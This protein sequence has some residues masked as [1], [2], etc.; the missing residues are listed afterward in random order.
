M[1]SRAL[2]TPHSH[3]VAGVIYILNIVHVCQQLLRRPGV[4]RSLCGR[5]RTRMCVRYPPK[6]KLT[7]CVRLRTRELLKQ[8]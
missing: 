4:S 3:R 8:T 1:L 6:K 2:R 7:L 5:V